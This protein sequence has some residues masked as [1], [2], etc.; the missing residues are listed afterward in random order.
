M[1]CFL[2]FGTKSYG[3]EL[4]YFA[5]RI[6]INPPA[7]LL[8]PLDS[9]MSLEKIQKIYADVLLDRGNYFYNGP[10]VFSFLSAEGKYEKG[11]LPKGT[12][13]LDI[14]KM[15]TQKIQTSSVMVAI[16]SGK[17]YGT[18]AE[19]GYAV[20]KGNIPVYVFPD[21]ALTREEIQDLWFVFQMGAMTSCLW[22]EEHFNTP[23]LLPQRTTLQAYRA[24]LETLK[25]SFL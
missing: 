15:I 23:S 24:F 1:L 20:A 17:A 21:P 9:T 22:Q 5:S 7:E 14:L 19:I 13:A 3:K 4:V 2:I 12:Q 11:R 8:L 18:I 10:W 25:P 6:P 16:V